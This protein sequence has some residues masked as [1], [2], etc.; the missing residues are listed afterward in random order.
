MSLK[1]ITRLKINNHEI[2]LPIMRLNYK[3]QF[4]QRYSSSHRIACRQQERTSETVLPSTAY[5]AIHK[6]VGLCAA[7]R[8]T[9]R[10]LFSYSRPIDIF[11][12]CR[13]CTRQIQG[14][15]GNT[16]GQQLCESL[17]RDFSIPQELYQAKLGTVLPTAW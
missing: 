4:L 14:T 9:L 12:F 13:N 5:S 7:S 10:R 17:L 15:T 16:R 2:K 8:N 11:P 6:V 1:L 3:L